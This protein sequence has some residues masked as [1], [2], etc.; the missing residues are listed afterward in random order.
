[1]LAEILELPEVA[2]LSVDFDIETIE[3]CCWL[4]ASAKADDAWK[5]AGAKGL[6]FESRKAAAYSA[7]DCE[8]LRQAKVVRRHFDN[9]R[10]DEL[11]AIYDVLSEYE[12][13]CLANTDRV[14]YLDWW[15]RER[16]KKLLPQVGQLTLFADT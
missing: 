14:Y 5:G 8:N 2:E 7:S 15:R 1:M 16:P 9:L 6:G 10:D 3:R 4:M 13:R 11:K 12:S